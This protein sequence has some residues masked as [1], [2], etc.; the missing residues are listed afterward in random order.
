M[1]DEE[2]IAN[3]ASEVQQKRITEFKS[4]IKG[5]IATSKAAYEK[6]DTP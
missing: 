5:M 6:S 1:N 3:I 2:R 4:A